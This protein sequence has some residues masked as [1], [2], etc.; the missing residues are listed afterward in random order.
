MDKIIRPPHKGI[1]AVVLINDKIIG[2]QQNC[3]LNRQMT[4]IKITNKING[5]W[6]DSIAGTRS[7]SINCTG[8]FIKDQEAW[9]IL[10]NAF[11][12]GQRVTVKLT[13]GT[14]NYTGEALVT[15]MPL[16]AIFNKAYTYSI[17][18]LGVGALQ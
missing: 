11:K 4:P 9:N 8:L 17:T 6:D 1:D 12:T 2:G 3:T 10:E 14:K 5:T 18:L 13:D 15:R 7:W 16:K